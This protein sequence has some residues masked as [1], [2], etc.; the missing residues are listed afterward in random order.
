[1][2]EEI[3][4]VTP[5][6]ETEVNTVMIGKHSVVE[7]VKLQVETKSPGMDQSKAVTEYHEKILMN[8][9]N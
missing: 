3:N 7:R 2:K 4:G 5:E 1:M 8:G 6:K 9:Y